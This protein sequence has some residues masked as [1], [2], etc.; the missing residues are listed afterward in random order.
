MAFVPN[1]KKLVNIP[2]NRSYGV[3][4]RVHPKELC[5]TPKEEKFGKSS[6]CM[7]KS[8]GETACSPSP[9]RSL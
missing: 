1:K 3:D 7:P 4:K 8:P 5:P 6:P 2:S 9:G